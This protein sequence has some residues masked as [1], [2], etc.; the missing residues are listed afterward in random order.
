MLCRTFPA[1][2]ALTFPSNQEVSDAPIF[3][4]PALE[5]SLDSFKESSLACKNDI[6][7]GAMFNSG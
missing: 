2:R 7:T 5:A 6:N 4:I 3:L 1:D